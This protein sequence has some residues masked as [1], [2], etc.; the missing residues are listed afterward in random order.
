MDSL[1]GYIPED[2]WEASQICD[3]VITRL[4]HINE[5]VIISSIRL[6]INMLDY[7]SKKD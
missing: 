7:I 3:R 6:I 4:N 2:E 1:V 5:G